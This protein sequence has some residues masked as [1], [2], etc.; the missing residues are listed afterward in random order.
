MEK[1]YK[2]VIVG[3]GPAGLAAALTF[4]RLGLGKEILVIE[5]Y[6]FPRYKCCAGYI[7]GKT[8]RVYGEFGLDVES[9]NYSLIKDFKIFYRYKKRQ[10]IDNKFLYTNRRIDRVELDNA[11]F[12]LAASKGIEIRENT[13]IASHDRAGH[14]LLT[15]D[16]ETIRYENLIFADGSGGYSSRY[17]EERPGNIAMQLVFA[18]EREEEI[19]IHFGVSA[20]GYGWVSSHGGFTNAGLTDRYDPALNYN[21]IFRGFLSDI[22]VE[23]DMAD[24]HGA[25]T[26][27]YVSDPITEDDIY[28][29]GDAAGACDPFTLSGLRYALGSGRTCAEAVA[30]GKKELYRRYMKGLKRRFAFMRLLMKIFYLRPVM[31][32][33][34]GIGCR[35]FGGLIAAVFNNFF[36]NKK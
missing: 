6:R 29:A 10:T 5:R 14:I 26:P 31:F 15:T 3:A 18:S 7:T 11:F 13:A 19:Q 12:K 27:M 22:G 2:A 33:V 8:R 16:G 35:F 17:R 23:A 32:C 34:F 28:Y 25:F 36:V 21:E 9:V 24:L 1:I 20:H 30:A 4:E